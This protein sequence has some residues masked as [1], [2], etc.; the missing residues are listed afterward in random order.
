MEE[1]R[2]R[3]QQKLVKVFSSQDEIE[4]GMVQALLRNA[5]IECMI[6]AEVA[7]GLFPANFGGLG[8]QDILVAEGQAEEAARIISEQH[9]A[10]GEVPE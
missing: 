9:E 5:G 1:S 3:S 8:R 2:D 10:G 6:N 7:P 4:A